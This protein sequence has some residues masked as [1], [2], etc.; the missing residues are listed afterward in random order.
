MGTIGIGVVI[1]VNHII[2]NVSVNNGTHAVN[3]LIVIF[4]AAVIL[5]SVYVGNCIKD[6]MATFL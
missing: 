1:Y 3:Q 2:R 5:I 6:N 4:F